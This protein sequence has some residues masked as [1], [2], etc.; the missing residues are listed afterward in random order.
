MSELPGDRPPGFEYW[1]G[2]VERIQ[3]TRTEVT[4]SDELISQSLEGYIYGLQ[5][6]RKRFIVS[7]PPEIELGSLKYGD[8]STERS[9]SIF[10]DHLTKEVNARLELVNK[11]AA[12][13]LR[14]FAI[15]FPLL[16]GIVTYVSTSGSLHWVRIPLVVALAF[17]FLSIL[18][19]IRILRV[20][21]WQGLYP[22]PVIDPKTYDDPVADFD[23]R[24]L[25]RWKMECVVYNHQIL[26][27]LMSVLSSAYINTVIMFTGLFYIAILSLFIN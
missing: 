13:L 6:I 15:A 10:A 21:N 20:E 22:Y 14:I 27:E 19:C 17:A 3:P 1:R 26:N 7:K 4:S 16:C 25:S 24:W 2:I 11:K 23:S 5:L 8:P 12:F 18:G 9:L